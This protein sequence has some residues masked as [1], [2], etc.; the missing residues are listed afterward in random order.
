MEFSIDQIKKVL[1]KKGYKFFDDELNIIG[2]RSKNNIA[3]SF[4]DWLCVIKD[5]NEPL[6]FPITTDPGTY[7]LNNPSSVDGTAILVP[8]QYINSHKIG[9]HQGK[10]EVLK[11]DKPLKVWRDNNMDNV[12]DKEGKIYQGIFGINIHRSNATSQ[13]TVVEKWSAGCQVF[14]KVDDF[15]HFMQICKDSKQSSF[16]YTLLEEIDFEK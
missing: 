9:L 6:V 7:W 10:Y 3:N 14:Q 12:L 2:I 16:T 8:G 5:N 4:D 1:T 13:S 11:Q 15:N